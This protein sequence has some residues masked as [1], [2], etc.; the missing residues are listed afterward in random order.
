MGGQILRQEFK[1]RHV[2]FLVTKDYFKDSGG[3]DIS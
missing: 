3:E 2:Y 1:G